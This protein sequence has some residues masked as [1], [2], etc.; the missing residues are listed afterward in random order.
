M[1]VDQAGNEVAGT[2]D[3]NFPGKVGLEATV[4]HHWDTAHGFEGSFL[5]VADATDQINLR[6]NGA[7]SLPVFGP[8]SANFH[9]LTSFNSALK[10]R[11]WGTEVN[12]LNHFRDG[13]DHPYRF[14]GILGFRQI[15]FEESLGFESINI[16]N[17]IG[18]YKGLS[19]NGIYAG[20][21]GAKGTYREL[22]PGLNAEAWFKV[23]LGGNVVDTRQS[24]ATGGINLP[25]VQGS[26]IRGT[27][28]SQILDFGFE[29]VYKLTE[30]VHLTLGY[31]LY[32]INKLGRATEQLQPDLNVTSPQPRVSGDLFLQ[33]IT[34]GFRCYWGHRADPNCR[35]GCC[36]PYI[37]LTDCN[38]QN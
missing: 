8:N 4:G 34:L 6:S 30:S 35:S 21:F 29:G 31:Q 18:L 32:F 2:Q 14:T 27:R 11:F 28:F 1:V 25:A 10:S 20:Q 37:M 13:T 38:C 19:S 22:L 3:F 36:T 5:W 23:G 15:A 16:A 17:A 9:N 12:Y 24:L 26:S 33:G 7:I